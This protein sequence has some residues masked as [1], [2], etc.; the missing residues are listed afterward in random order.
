MIRAGQRLYDERLRKGLTIE[1]VEKATKI[2][3]SFLTAIEKAEYVK[4]PPFAYSQGF[5]K[6]Y[7]DFLGLPSK[8][9][10]ALFRREFGKKEQ[11]RVL[12]KEFT[13]NQYKKSWFRLEQTIFF[14][15][16]IFLFLFFYILFQY[17][18]LILNPPLEVTH[19]QE[20]EKTQTTVQVS[21]KTDNNATVFVNDSPVTIDSNG[22]FTKV[23]SEFSGSA[24]IHIKAQNRF[25]KTSVVER[26]IQVE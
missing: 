19:P 22:N 2:R 23:I 17:R 12:P 5:V 16:T 13:D 8:E 25:G 7:A 1:E 26:H 11:V 20:G 10:L 4:L 9:I 21:G 15:I 6:N 14:V 24:V 3:A 18:F